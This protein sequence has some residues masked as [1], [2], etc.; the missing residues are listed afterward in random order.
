MNTENH[1]H[2]HRYQQAKQVTL[3]GALKNTI[4]GILKVVLGILGNSHALT[5]DGIHSFSDLLTDIL[6]LF[7]SRWGCQEADSNHPYGHQRIETAASMFLAFLLI[8]V[9]LLI[10]YDAVMH[11]FA[12]T[13]SYETPAFYV[14]I[15]AGVSALF[16][17]GLFHYTRHT[18]KK[19]KSD[20]L[21]ANAWH[22]R[23]D[24][25]S[26][27]VV[28]IGV[29]GAYF[30]YYWF[31]PLAAGI[32]GIMIVKMGGELAWTSISELVDTG[33]E[34]EI[35]ENIT[36]IIT[37]TKGVAAIH[38][39]RTRSMGG[40]IFVDVHVLVN[41]K[42][43][44]S[45]AHYIAEQVYKN[46]L[47]NIDEVKDVTVHID[48][49]DDTT[50]SKSLDL[51]TRE[52][53]FELLKKHKDLDWNAY[54]LDANLHYLEG[55]IYLELYELNKDLMDENIKDISPEDVSYLLESISILGDI[56]VYYT[57][58]EKNEKKDEK[59]N[60]VIA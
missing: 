14:L 25:F 13:K 34:P 44:V 31:D 36:K 33:V 15:V 52:E 7:A 35:L 10:G 28:F 5:A 1:S 27:I 37:L 9:G 18:A 23:S 20:L 8:S 12:K 60:N 49:E 50:V 47:E 16:N 45:E 11:F 29:V 4:L 38:Q 41:P 58:N 54:A 24:A 53:L 39:L 43:T 48:S 59:A 42:L 21:M 40:A 22:H 51:P 19:I 57:Q 2:H 30:G 46:L 32:V 56:S 6:V 17:E 55:K 3:V 26:S